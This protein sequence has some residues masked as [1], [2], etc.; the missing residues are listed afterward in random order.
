[1]RNDNKKIWF[2]EKRQTI[3]KEIKI[4]AILD[5]AQELNY[6]ASD[7]LRAVGI[8]TKWYPVN[9][10]IEQKLHMKLGIFDN[11]IAVLGSANWSYQ[12][13]EVNHECN[14]LI[15]DHK[16]VSELTKMYEIDWN[17]SSVDSPFTSYE[18]DILFKRNKW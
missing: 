7:K 12:G 16:I 4:R 17:K 14:V 1:M 9:M 18:L 6:N 2:G 5:P 3:E 13:F 11:Y 15:I 10:D 8:S